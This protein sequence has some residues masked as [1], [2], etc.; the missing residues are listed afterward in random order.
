M[1]STLCATLVLSRILLF[2]VAYTSCLFLI[3][4]RFT[5][6]LPTRFIALCCLYFVTVPSP[7]HVLLLCVACLSLLLCAASHCHCCCVAHMLLFCVT[8]TWSYLVIA[9]SKEA[10]CDYRHHCR[11]IQILLHTTTALSHHCRP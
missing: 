5:V 11:P 4:T 2:R 8:D 7:T 10:M 1:L 6:L 3:Y 9:V